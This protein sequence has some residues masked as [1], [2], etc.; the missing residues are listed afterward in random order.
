[1]SEIFKAIYKS[2][3]LISG[4][5][6]LLQDATSLKSLIYYLLVI[7]IALFL[8]KKVIIFAQGIGPINNPIGQQLTKT[9][10]RFCNYLSVRDIKSYELLKSWGI[11]ADLVCDPIFSTKIEEP[12]KNPVVAVQLRDYKTV[13]KDFIDRLA[14]KIIQ[15]FPNKSIEIFS[16]QDSI[17]LERCNQLAN[18]IKMLS[19]DSNVAVFNELSDEDVIEKISKAEYLIAMRFHAIIVGLLSSVK[20]LGINYDIKVEK[21]ATEFN[22]P[23]LHLQK[24]FNDEFKQLKEQ[25][26]TTIQAQISIKNFNWEGFEK[27]INN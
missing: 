10:L 13:T 14:Q 16:F 3:Y 7:C 24:D 11:N 1:M 15:E 19:P 12:Q 25:D 4:G 18:A 6:S 22:I 20:T 5:G 2:D 8:R 21:L 17:D 23:I 26:L 27:A 9:I